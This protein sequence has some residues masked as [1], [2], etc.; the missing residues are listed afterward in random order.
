MYFC[1]KSEEFQKMYLKKL[2]E[3]MAR[4]G[5]NSEEIKESLSY[6]EFEKMSNIPTLENIENGGDLW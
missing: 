4:D 5:Y 1:Q 2:A 6:I 3:R